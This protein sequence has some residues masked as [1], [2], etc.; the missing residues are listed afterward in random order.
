VAQ[1]NLDPSKI[2]KKK[3]LFLN[4]V[5]SLIPKPAEIAK[6]MDSTVR[7][8]MRVKGVRCNE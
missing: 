4:D 6:F 3:E 1:L 2:G 8:K 7:R 5:D